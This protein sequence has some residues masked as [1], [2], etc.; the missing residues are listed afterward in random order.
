MR[1]ASFLVDFGL[2]ATCAL[3]AALLE[4]DA[5]WDQLQ[6]HFWYPWQLLHGG[7]TDP[8]L[9]GGRFQNPLPQVPFFLLADSL[10]PQVAQALLG[11]MAG[12]AAVLTRR[13]AMRVLPFDGGW[14]VA[15]ST[16]A[17]VLAMVG[18]GFR[19]ELATSYSDVLLASLL[20]GGLLLILRAQP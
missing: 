11:A 19:S 16:G 3:I 8:D 9:Y 12:V 1:R 15:V 13:I 6:Y 5:N 18:A 4:Q 7:F 17:A 10:N 20:L 14:Q 2:I